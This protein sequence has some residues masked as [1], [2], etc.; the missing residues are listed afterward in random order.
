ML[1]R[2]VTNAVEVEITPCEVA[3]PIDLDIEAIRLEPAQVRVR[4]VGRRASAA[5]RIA[6]HL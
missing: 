4:H 3:T 5:A 2:K 6:L 1:F